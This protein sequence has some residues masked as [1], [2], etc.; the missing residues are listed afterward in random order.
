VA[1]LN[2]LDG[3][4]EARP[5]DPVLDKL[6]S[7]WHGLRGDRPAPMRRDLDPAAIAYGLDR[8]AL[9]EVL[10]DGDLRCLLAGQQLVAALGR[11]AT[12]LLGS[13]VLTR[14]DRPDIWAVYDDAISQC[15]P[16]VGDGSMRL[17]DGMLIPYSRL[18][19]PLLDTD[20]RVRWLLAAYHLRWP[21]TRR[22]SLLG[23]I[24]PN[25]LS[26]VRRGAM[27]LGRAIAGAPL[28][29]VGRAGARAS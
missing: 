25:F 17:P 22:P 23:R 2:I 10:D 6:L 21:P 1:K 24:G 3:A 18:L 7:Y 13:Q 14:R 26:G 27:T 4:H 5:S 16:R 11:N 15:R 20:D 28:A 8:I 19:L 12:N 9:V 29:I